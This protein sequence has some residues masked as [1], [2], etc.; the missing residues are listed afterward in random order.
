M[1]SEVVDEITWKDPPSPMPGS[2]MYEGFRFRV[3]LPDTPGAI[4]FFRTVNICEKG[5]DRYVDLP[6]ET[7]TAST[8]GLPEKLGKFMTATPT[9]A[10][11]IIL[12]K[13][14]R[15]EYPWVLPEQP[16]APGA[17]R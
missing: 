3:L 5:D 10:P 9:P 8:P 13:P 16:K 12:V 4:L 14:N 2:L 17:K 15:P 11:F 7:L 6:T 1:I